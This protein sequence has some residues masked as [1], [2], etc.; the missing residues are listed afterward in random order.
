M[1]SSGGQVAQNDQALQDA[2]L[3]ANTN[4]LNNAKTAF[5]E[6][7]A[8]QA[9][10]TA[11]A[12]NMMANP[13]GYT[14]REL[15]IQTT[16]VNENFARSARQALGSAAAFA[17][18]HGGADVAG[19]GAAQIAGQIGATAATGKA[20][21]LADIQSRNEEMKRQSMLTGLQELNTAGG[22]A[23]GAVGGTISGAGTT[24]GTTVDAGTAVTAAQ[25][26]S[27]GDVT[28]VLS[29]LSGLA[30]AGATAYAGR[31]WIAAAIYGGWDDPRTSLVR[32][33]IFGDFSTT[34]YGRALAWLYEQTGERISK[35]PLL[36]RM[37]TPIFNLA[38]RKAQEK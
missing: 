36:V 19:G 16:G 25:Q 34:W 5:G 14:P 33:Y 21:A 26:A 18:A 31:C 2:N 23:Q 17:A 24:G 37:L 1:C 38:L 4:F 32:S 15:A 22:A 3:A 13:M 10:Q 20:G 8:V 29:G 9:K 30:Q 27:W 12:N 28:G 11:L 6:Q 7:Q 35:R